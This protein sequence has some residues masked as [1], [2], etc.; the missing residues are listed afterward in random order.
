MIQI[1]CVGSADSGNYQPL[2]PKANV[3]VVKWVNGVEHEE[4]LPMNHAEKLPPL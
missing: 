3:V 2:A 4:S 1:A